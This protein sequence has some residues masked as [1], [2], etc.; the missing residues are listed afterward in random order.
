MAKK[1]RQELEKEVTALAKRLK[2]I[3]EE[4]KI[5]AESKPNLNVNLESKPDPQPES[6][7]TTTSKEDLVTPETLEEYKQVLLAL[8]K[9]KQLGKDLDTTLEI[10]NKFE[11]LE[12]ELISNRDR[13]EVSHLR[14]AI[15]ALRAKFERLFATVLAH[16]TGKDE[17]I[18][19][20]S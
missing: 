5:G 17:L 2:T 20:A 4:K 6:A 15:V 8:E 16:A 9:S 10:L 3:E 18:N 13:F 19:D 11:K 12:A 14:L 1:S 7:P